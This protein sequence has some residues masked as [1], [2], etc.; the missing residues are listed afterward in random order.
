[1]VPVDSTDGAT[2]AV[3]G[4]IHQ[5]VNPQLGDVPDLEGYHQRED[6]HDVKLGEELPEDQ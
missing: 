2:V 6:V 5:D 3:P 1:M 4:V